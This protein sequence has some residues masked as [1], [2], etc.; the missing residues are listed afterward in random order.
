M[1]FDF[2]LDPSVRWVLA[3]SILIGISSGVLGSFAL[4]RRR[5]LMGDAVAHAALPGVAVAF[6][7]AGTRSL[8]LMLLGALVAGLLGAFF[9]QSV[10]KHTRIKEDT[11]L[12]LILSVFFA[13][14]IVLLTQIQHSGAGGQAG[15]DKYLFGQAAALI[16]SD[17]QMMAVSAAAVCVIAILMFKEFKLLCFDPG[18]AKGIGFSPKVLD[19]MLMF[20][21]VVTV[22][23]GMQSVGVVLMA[24]MLIIPAASARF[25]TNKLSLM[26]TLAALFG[27]VSGAI[28]TLLS[29]VGLRLPTGPLIVLAASAVFA[30]SMLFAPDR[31]IL[32]RIARRLSLRGRVAKENALRDFYE[33]AEACDCWDIE[34]TATEL[35]AGRGVR[36]S[37]MITTLRKLVHEGLVA[38]AGGR[39]RLTDEGLAKAYTITRRHRLW[40]MFLMHEGQLGSDH[41]H[42]DA[43]EVEHHMPTELEAELEKLLAF[44]GIEMKLPPS[45]HPIET[46]GGV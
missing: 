29:T 45:I 36:A 23:I 13:F 18:F 22:V 32:A 40:E 19:G 33:L 5:S 15:L 2:L 3:G 12:G 46:Q 8:P 16:G 10:I 30:V 39:Y 34:A 26:V 6:I 41:V 44:Q 38:E 25:W 28:G 24:A 11:A 31:G 27:A 1:S 43:D 7:L 42:R 17:V 35:A 21:I 20:L 37:A 9:I 14:G 4:L